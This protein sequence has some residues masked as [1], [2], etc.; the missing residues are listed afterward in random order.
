MDISKLPIQKALP[1]L[2]K[3]L[4]SHNRVILEAMPGAGKTTGVPLALLK[5]GL[6]GNKKIVMLEPR[7][8]AARSTSQFMASQLG[9]ELGKTV[10]YQVRFENFCGP[11]TKVE[12]L[13]EGILTRRIQSDPE[14][15]DVGILIFDE[16][17]ER[18]LQSDLALA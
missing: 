17:H 5:S 18:N 8:I 13:T 11:H 2:I 14:L 12:V 10:G 3:E 15:S 9:E 6:P 4:N 16:F 1:E 7:R